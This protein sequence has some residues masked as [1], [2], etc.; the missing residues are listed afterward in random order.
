MV[1][2]LALGMCPRDLVRFLCVFLSKTFSGGKD[3][4]KS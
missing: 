3:R 4:E 1:V 2:A